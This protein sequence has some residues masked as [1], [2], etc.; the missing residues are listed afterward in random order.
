MNS[1]IRDSAF[2]VKL[3]KAYTESLLELNIQTVCIEDEWTDT[4]IAD[5]QLKFAD[6]ALEIW[7][8]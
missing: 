2:E 8:F 6:K 5:R 1:T 3:E 4:V 7:K